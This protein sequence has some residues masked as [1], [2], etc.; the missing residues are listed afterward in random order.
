M[1][2]LSILCLAMEYMNLYI[3]CLHTLDRWHV[4]FVN[5]FKWHQKIINPTFECLICLFSLQKAGRL[6]QSTAQKVRAVQHQLWSDHMRSKKPGWWIL[7]EM[8]RKNAD[9]PLGPRLLWRY[10]WINLFQLYRRLTIAVKS[11]Q[12]IS[13]K[14]QSKV[15]GNGKNMIRDNGQACTKMHVNAKNVTIIT[16]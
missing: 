16:T 12:S 1:L 2:R 15:R 13:I 7:H 4:I 8:W 3:N 5:C 6:W 11:T 14:A 9:T 10:L